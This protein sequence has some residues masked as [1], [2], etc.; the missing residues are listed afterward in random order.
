[1]NEARKEGTNDGRT[2]GRMGRMGKMEGRLD[3][4]KDGKDGK[5]GRKEGNDEGRRLLV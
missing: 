2:E 4:S 3:E 5:E 1:M